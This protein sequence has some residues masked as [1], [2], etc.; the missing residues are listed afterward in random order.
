MRSRTGLT[1]AIGVAVLAT[2]M[3]IA[4]V[5]INRS[6]S[7]DSDPAASASPSIAVS[8]SPA[9]STTAPTVPSPS[10]STTPSVSLSCA[11]DSPWDCEQQQRFAA[12]TA[13]LDE[14]PGDLAVIVQDRRTDAVWSAGTT[15][16]T[17]WTASTIK[18]AI[19]ATILEWDRAG[20]ITIDAETTANMTDALV[21]SSNDAAT[22]LW[23]RYGGQPM[24]DRFRSTY[25]MTALSVVPGYDLFWRN[26]QCSAEDLHHL[27]LYVLTN[28]HLDD[29]TYII[30][31]LRGV[32]SNQQWG[33][34]AVGSP[35]KPG[36][37]NGW[38]E[39]TDSSG[40]HWVTHTV[41]FAGPSQQYIIVAT[42]DLPPSGTMSDGVHAVS[43]LIATVF[44]E[45]VPARVNIP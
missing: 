25:Q 7:S 39:K 12:A 29:R 18:L 13:F 3:G 14:K 38:A 27:M 31:Q 45:A 37:K 33:V 26:L 43:D 6:R 11:S 1:V 40:T 36:N 41:G 16:N 20:K 24:F 17:T 32:A 8:L 34:W 2:V 10:A 28:L 21:N 4:A 35:L 9:D 44:G 30:E 5:V 15:G 23:Y 22:A 42:Y 19:V